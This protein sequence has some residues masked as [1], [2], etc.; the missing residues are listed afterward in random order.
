MIRTGQPDTTRALIAEC[1]GFRR[2]IAKL[3]EVSDQ[4]CQVKLEA[5][6]PAN[7]AP[8]GARR[9]LASKIVTQRWNPKAPVS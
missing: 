3:I 4:A 7:A 5:E 6:G 1:R 2:L 8:T 9:W